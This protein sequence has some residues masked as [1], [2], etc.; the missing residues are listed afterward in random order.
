MRTKWDNASQ[1]VSLMLTHSEG[2]VA[3]RDI[4]YYQPSPLGASRLESDCFRSLR[5]FWK[6]L[7]FPWS[8]GLFYV[9]AAVMFFFEGWMGLYF[10]FYL[11]PGQGLFWPL[12][13]KRLINKWP[14]ARV[15]VGVALV[16]HSCRV[17]EI[18]SWFR[19]EE[20]LGTACATPE[21][22]DVDAHK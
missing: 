6:T 14:W 2:S 4:Y 19:L 15:T 22:P 7:A 8:S 13:S 11:E 5:I 10:Y 3:V 9:D 20:L 16:L 1:G 18:G 17:S 21:C 12:R